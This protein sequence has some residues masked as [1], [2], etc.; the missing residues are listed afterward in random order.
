[1]IGQ[2]RAEPAVLGAIVGDPFRTLFLA[3]FGSMVALARLLGADDPE[4]IAQDAFLAL[5]TRWDKLR[6]PA[7]AVGY[8]RRSVLNLSRNRLRHLGVRRRLQPL[9]V[10]TA[11]SAE[12]TAVVREEVAELLAAI[13]AL[14]RRRREALVLRH[15]LGLDYEEIAGVLGVSQPSARSLISRAMAQ[16]RAQQGERG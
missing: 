11:P 12:A 14:P 6:D 15:W 10:P 3:E 8:L 9:P 1:M 13:A 2:R 5:H 4:A 7:A 16:L